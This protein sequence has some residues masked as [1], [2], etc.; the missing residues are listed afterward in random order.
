MGGPSSAALRGALRYYS[1]TVPYEIKLIERPPGAR[2]VPKQ[3]QVASRTAGGIN[4]MGTTN[5]YEFLWTPSAQQAGQ[6][7]KAVLEMKYSTPLSLRSQVF[8]LTETQTLNIHVAG[9]P[10]QIS[11]DAGG[12]AGPADISS[13]GDLI[14]FSQVGTG[15]RRYNRI[16]GTFVQVAQTE[17]VVP[18]TMS[19]SG[20]F[21]GLAY[22]WPSPSPAFASWSPPR[23]STSRIATTARSSS[24]GTWIRGAPAS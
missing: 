21:V 16:S 23:G 7:F 12:I 1:L 2:L 11:V 9:I 15:V 8:S 22:G 17:R 4:G 3:I 6:D 10:Q 14:C 18:T 24:S 5:G 19:P 20:R 13:N